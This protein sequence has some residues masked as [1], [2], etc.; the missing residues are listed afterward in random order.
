MKEAKCIKTV[1]SYLKEIISQIMVIICKEI[2]TEVKGISKTIILKEITSKIM[3]IICKEI[4]TEVK[5]IKTMMI[6]LKETIL[7]II[8][9]MVVEMKQS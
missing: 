5:E 2:I 6:I 3:V 7:Q 9:W 1:M 8:M 4:I